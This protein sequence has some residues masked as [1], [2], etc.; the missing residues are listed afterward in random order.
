MKI[1][2]IYELTMIFTCS[3]QRSWFNNYSSFLS[4]IL[5]FMLYFFKTYFDYSHTLHCDNRQ[6]NNSEAFQICHLTQQT[7]QNSINYWYHSIRPFATNSLFSWGKTVLLVKSINHIF[8]IQY[9]EYYTVT[10]QISVVP[11]WEIGTF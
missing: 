9:L 7:V 8:I 3:W 1:M 11:V 4:S 6:T 2:F 5:W 10:S